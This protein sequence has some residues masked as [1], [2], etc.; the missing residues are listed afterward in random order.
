MSKPARSIFVFGL[1][2][3]ATGLI[4]FAIPNALLGLLRLTPTT[5]P[6]I[7]VLGV[8]VGVQGALHVAAARQEL[9]GF[10]RATIWARGIVLFALASLVV[11]DW[12]PPILIGFGL[13]D[14]AGAVW[15]RAALR[16]Q[17]GAA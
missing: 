5:E 1:Y 14:T 15:T 4:L 11:L 13:V 6:W 7:R 16:S 3:V 9:T 8:A 12:A 10:F 17:T 2:L